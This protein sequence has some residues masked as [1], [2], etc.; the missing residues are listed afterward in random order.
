MNNVFYLDAAELVLPENVYAEEESKS[1]K[2]MYRQA[3]KYGETVDCLY[4][5]TDTSRSVVL[6]DEKGAV[7]AIIEFEKQRV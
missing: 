4:G 6:K 2:I 5:E 7:R 1:F 3:I